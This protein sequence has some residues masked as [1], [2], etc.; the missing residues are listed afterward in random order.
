MKRVHIFKYALCSDSTRSNGWSSAKGQGEITARGA[1]L[2]SV[3][4]CRNSGAYKVKKIQTFCK[5]Q[6]RFCIFQKN[7][8][9]SFI[10][11]LL[12]HYYYI[13]YPIWLLCL[14]AVTS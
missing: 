6:A 14:V 2:E 4:G 10:V 11:L 7:K 3:H 12:L 8:I 1:P 5:K 9:I 13:R